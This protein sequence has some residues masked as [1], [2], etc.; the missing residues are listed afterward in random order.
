MIYFYYLYKLSKQKTDYQNIDLLTS[1]FD[2]ISTNNYNNNKPSNQ[3]QALSSNPLEEE[4]KLNK[5]QE[6][7]TL[8]K[9]NTNNPNPGLYG[10]G[11]QQP[12]SK[13]SVQQNP[14]SN[15]NLVKTPQIFVE[16][17]NT[18]TNTFDE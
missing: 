4:P 3:K 12:Q 2:K 1:E 11:N 17:K 5:V 6:T 13:I 10:G 14:Q 18:N 9:N 8:V 16:N 15:A 7:V